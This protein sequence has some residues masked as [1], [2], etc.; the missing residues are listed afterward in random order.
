MGDWV[1]TGPTFLANGK[2]CNPQF[3][4]VCVLALHLAVDAKQKK[5]RSPATALPGPGG[6]TT[7]AQGR[8]RPQLKAAPWSDETLTE[9]SAGA[10]V[11]D[12]VTGNGGLDS[13]RSSR[14]RWPD[15]QCSGQPAGSS[16]RQTESEKIAPTGIEP[17]MHPCQPE[18]STNLSPL[19]CDQKHWK[20]HKQ[21]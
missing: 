15:D 8:Q 6:K 7:T 16:S 4:T 21:G 20:A 1:G 11:S 3:G 13:A 19:P 9:A 17:A 14:T 18:P 10:H 5:S 2:N 12:P